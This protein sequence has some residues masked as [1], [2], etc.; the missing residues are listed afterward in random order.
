MCLRV[1]DKLGR[2]L[3]LNLPETDIMDLCVCMPRVRMAATIVRPFT[4]GGIKVD[5]AGFRCGNLCWSKLGISTPK[6]FDA[7]NPIKVEWG[8]Y[9]PFCSKYRMWSED[10]LLSMPI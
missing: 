8:D 10:V 3:H 1:G 2:N 6:E 9:F 4:F 7:W 5:T